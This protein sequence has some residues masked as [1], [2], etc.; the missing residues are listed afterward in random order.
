MAYLLVGTLGLAVGFLAD[1]WVPRLSWVRLC[2]WTVCFG[3]IA[4]GLALVSIA[5][6]KF[7]L[8]DWVVPAGWVLLPVASFLLIYSLFI[9]L[10]L[11]RTY[12]RKDDSPRLVTTGT[13]ALV[14]HP[15]VLWYL[16]ILVALLLVSR[17]WLLLVAAP[18]W[19]MLGGIFKKCVNSQAVYLLSE[20]HGLE[21]QER[22]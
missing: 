2:L 5:G 13:Y 22:R 18:L 4:S 17:S 1:S 6:P 3:L 8:H 21:A 9:E 15:S 12:V 11:A 10:P 7:Q 20:Q 16:L 19:A 14:R